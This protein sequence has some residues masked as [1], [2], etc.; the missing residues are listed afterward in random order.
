MMMMARWLRIA[1]IQ[2]CRRPDV[3]DAVPALF[4]VVAYHAQI[5]HPSFTRTT[6]ENRGEN[7]RR[8]C[9]RKVDDIRNPGD[10]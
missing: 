1:T 8:A 7:T 5:V 9:E 2:P 4:D 3:N 6:V 10:S